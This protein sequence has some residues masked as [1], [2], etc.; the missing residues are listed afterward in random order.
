MFDNS[1]KNGPVST[2]PLSE[3]LRGLRLDGVDYGRFQMT[4]P[5]GLNFPAQP[6]ARFHFVTG[7]GC[8]LRKAEND[9]V[10][11]KQGDAVLLPRGAEHA[12]ASAPSPCT[13]PSKCCTFQKVCEN[14]VDARGGGDGDNDGGGEK[15]VLFSASMTFNVDGLHPLLRMMPDV[16]QV[17]ELTANEPRVPDLLATMA[18]EVALDRVGAGGILARLADVVAASLIRSWVERGCGDATGWIAAARDPDIGRVLAAIHL[19]PNEDW[20]IETL[21]KVMRAS[22]S[23]FA[24]RFTSV[25]GE[26]P[27]RYVAQVRMHQARQWLM[28]DKLRIS[29]VAR[30]LGYDSEASFSRA[31]KR[32][33]GAAPS[34]FRTI[35]TD[36]ADGEARSASAPPQQF[37]SS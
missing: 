13:A 12:L 36:N 11:I 17:C 1:S 26:T 34:H 5:W 23:A 18:C 2:D 22:R 7:Q 25:V 30:R 27:A 10:P 20:T 16:M 14:I 33:M 6:A 15:T 31:F 4:A 32:V 8:W 3:M 19:N 28:R 9:W 37:G 29:V 24:A 21:A 35:E